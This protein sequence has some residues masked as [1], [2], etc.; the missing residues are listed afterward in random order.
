MERRIFLAYIKIA[1]Y[2][3][4]VR[5]NEVNLAAI[6][7]VSRRVHIGICMPPFRIR[8]RHIRNPRSYYAENFIVASLNVSRILNILVLHNS[9]MVIGYNKLVPGE[10][11]SLLKNIKIEQLK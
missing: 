9:I 3:S 8:T 5:N 10:N 4:I 1:N 6:C 2:R 7:R 11:L